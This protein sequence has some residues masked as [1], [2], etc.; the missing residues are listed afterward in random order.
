MPATGS[1]PD[2]RVESKAMAPPDTA[3]FVPV[4]PRT[5]TPVGGL[6]T[7]VPLV[8]FP[9]RVESRFVSSGTR[10][11][12]L[13]RVYPDEVQVDAHDPGLTENERAWGCHF[14]T[15]MWLAGGDDGAMRT[16]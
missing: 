8:L 5:S 11:E 3:G 13:V 10:T 1:M 9:V 2:G 16:A 4:I 14:W 7:D 15:Q 12:L 6:K